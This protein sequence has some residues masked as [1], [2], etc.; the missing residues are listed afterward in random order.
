MA[1]SLQRACWLAAL[2]LLA[3]AL[4]TPHVASA[5]RSSGL[6]LEVPELFL[7]GGEE[8]G[9]NDH[10]AGDDDGQR[11]MRVG[12][13]SDGADVG[14]AASLESMGSYRAQ[15]ARIRGDDDEEGDMDD[16]RYDGDRKPAARTVRCTWYMGMSYAPGPSPCAEWSHAGVHAAFIVAVQLAF[17]RP[18]SC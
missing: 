18:V 5:S 12:P 1:G 10:T 14:T 7:G 17:Q 13:G 16:K 11:V 6:L 2:A 15:P 4:C 9:A 8:H 3:S